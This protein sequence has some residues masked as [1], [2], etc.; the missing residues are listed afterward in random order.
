MTKI[1]KVFIYELTLMIL[2]KKITIVIFFIAQAKLKL[3]CLQN[4]K[5]EKTQRLIVK[6]L[7]GLQALDNRG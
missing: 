6:S 3:C 2:M 5:Y 4:I 7:K 1:T